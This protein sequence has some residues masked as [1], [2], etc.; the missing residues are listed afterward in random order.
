MSKDSRAVFSASRDSTFKI[1][2]SSDG[3]VRR[4]LACQAPL[5]CSD[6]TADEKYI[7]FGAEDNCVYMYSM[8]SCQVGKLEAHNNFVTGLCVLEDRIVTCSLDAT[9]RVRTT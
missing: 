5:T 1:S 7:F 9:I 8:E 4:N 6:S 2:S 3:V